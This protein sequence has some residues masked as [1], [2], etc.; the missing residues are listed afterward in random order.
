[1]TTRIAVFL[2]ALLAWSS[3]WA[4]PTGAPGPLFQPSA[5]ALA[6]ADEEDPPPR[7]DPRLL[8]KKPDKEVVPQEETPIYKTWWFWALTAAVVGGTVVFG[9]STF[10]PAEHFPHACP[11]NAVACFGDGRT[12]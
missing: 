2:L 1:M 9:V 7:D 8:Q 12:P 3:A 4:T 6:A 5:R 10:K 11:S